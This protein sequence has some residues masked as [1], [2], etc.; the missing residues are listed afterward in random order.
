MAHFAKL[1]QDNTVLEVLVV[2]DSEEHRGAEFLAQDLGLGGNWIQT[3]FTGK[4]RATFA[5]PGMK[6]LPDADKFMPEKPELNPSFVFDEQLWKWIPPV[7]EPEDADL[8]IGGLKQ[9]E[10]EDVEIEVEG[11]LLPV[12][13]FILPENPK[14]YSWNEESVSWKLEEVPEPTTPKPQQ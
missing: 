2:P 14:I 11:K 5:L 9:P 10:T 1:D 7:P 6:Y 12:K 13:Q 3:S 8:V 4:I